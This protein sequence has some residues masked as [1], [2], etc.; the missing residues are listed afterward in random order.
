[1]QT[2][3][4]RRFVVSATIDLLTDAVGGVINENCRHPTIVIKGRNKRA[5]RNKIQRKEKTRK[6]H[7][8]KLC[9]NSLEPQKKPKKKT[10]GPLESAFVI[11]TRLAL[12]KAR[13]RRFVPVEKCRN[14]ATFATLFL[15]IDKRSC[16][17]RSGIWKRAKRKSITAYFRDRKMQKNARTTFEFAPRRAAAEPWN[18]VIGL[19]F[20]K[21]ATIEN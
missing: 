7:F 1:L 14:R 2:L 10:G 18:R 15:P 16:L 19:W 21:S 13:S 12:L 5:T 8:L 11:A 17:V 20:W 9:W 6:E 4:Q 3:V